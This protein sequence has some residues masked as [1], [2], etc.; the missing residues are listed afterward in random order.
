MTACLAKAFLVINRFFKH[1][2]D[3]GITAGF[4]LTLRESKK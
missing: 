2:I 1:F 4:I 3:P